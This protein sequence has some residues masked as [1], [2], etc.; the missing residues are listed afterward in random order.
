MSNDRP[1]AP[2]EHAPQCMTQTHVGGRCNCGAAAAAGDRSAAREIETA[3]RDALDAA[4][5]SAGRPLSLLDAE[6]LVECELRANPAIVARVAEAAGLVEGAVVHVTDEA[7]GEEYDA[8]V[9][10][11]TVTAEPVSEADLVAGRLRF[12]QSVQ[13]RRLTPV[14]VEVTLDVGRCAPAAAPPAEDT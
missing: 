9:G 7:T 14:T 10:P 11:V 8:I 1:P 13:L 2:P 6:V 12:V 4:R 5:A 3:L